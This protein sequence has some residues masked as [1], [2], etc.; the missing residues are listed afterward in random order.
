MDNTSMCNKDLGTF[1][2]SIETRNL[3]KPQTPGQFHV[4]YVCTPQACKAGE[5]WDAQDAQQNIVT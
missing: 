2:W 4:A 1:K 5:I 3:P